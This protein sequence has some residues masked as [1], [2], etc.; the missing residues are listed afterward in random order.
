MELKTFSIDSDF[1]EENEKF[2]SLIVKYESQIKKLCEDF[3]FECDKNNIET[4]SS[5]GWFIH[6]V[7]SELSEARLNLS[8]EKLIKEKE[9]EALEEKNG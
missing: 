8:Y 9:R 4:F 3:I 1:G 2:H 5:D 6:V 7:A